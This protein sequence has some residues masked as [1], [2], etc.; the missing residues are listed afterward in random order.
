MSDK[1][2]KKKE[3]AAP[4]EGEKKKKGGIGALLTKLPVL[5]GGV[6]IIE[7]FVLFAGF[8]MIGGGPSQAG[9]AV[10][11]PAHGESSEKAEGGHGEG[12]HGEGGHGEG[13]E[14]GAPAS[15]A[16]PKKPVELQ[17]VEFRAPNS[18]SGRM[19][20]YDVSIV[21][22]VKQKNQAT[23]EALIKERG[24]LLKD[25]VRTII[26]QS[27]PQKLTGGSEPGLETLRRQ[28]K[29][30]LDEIIGEGMVDEVLVPKCIP[31]RTDF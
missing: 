17:V 25:R 30:Q 18:Q 19:F 3:E 2:E 6:M 20:L 5:L 16:D 13:A 12:G 29:F 8:K 15:P 9:A 10:D 14:G 31:F 7:A 22:I 21:A 4:A 27:E 1:P 11:L 28:V 23:V 24:G 26:A